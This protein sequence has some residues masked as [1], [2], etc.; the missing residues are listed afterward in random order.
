MKSISLEKDI[1]KHIGK[2]GTPDRDKFEA[3]LQSEIEA[4]KRRNYLL[5]KKKGREQK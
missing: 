5:F 1:E 4:I 2:I 3:E